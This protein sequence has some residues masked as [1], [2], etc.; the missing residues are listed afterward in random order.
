[1]K[2]LSLLFPAIFILCSCTN[3]IQSNDFLVEKTEKFSGS[4]KF[5]ELLSHYRLIP[6]ETKPECLIGGN[7]AKISE[8]NDLI[9]INSDNNRLLVFDRT[10]RF[11]RQIASQ[12]PGPE[13]YTLLRDFD[14]SKNQIAILD[15]NKVNLYSLEG[16]FK[17]SIELPEIGGNI[18]LL[19]NNNIML[20]TGGEDPILIIN[21]EGKIIDRFLNLDQVIQIAKHTP[22]GV[23]QGEICFQNGGFGNDIWLYNPTKRQ[24]RLLKLINEGKTLNV[25]EENKLIKEVGFKYTSNQDLCIIGELASTESHLVFCS[26]YQKHLYINILNAMAGDG[27]RYE[28]YPNSQIEDNITFVGTNICLQY[29]Y[30]LSSSQKYFYSYIYPF[31][32]NESIKD[33]NGEN[34]ES[35]YQQITELIRGLP[36]IENANPILFE[37]NFK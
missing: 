15:I 27:V 25:E 31:I 12:G 24:G 36:D 7:V 35:A 1:M 8:D 34:M 14:V 18:K 33:Y 9:Y 10:G 28:I 26:K 37:F 11:V 4:T 16:I 21:E 29:V 5:S 22:F 23:W 6:L 17:K 13:E 20:R 2:R 19:P 30:A 3:Q 32:I